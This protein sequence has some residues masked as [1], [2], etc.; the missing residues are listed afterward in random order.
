MALTNRFAN[1]YNNTDSYSPRNK[2][3][4]IKKGSLVVDGYDYGKNWS[5]ADQVK[6]DLYLKSL[7]FDNN[8]DM[9][10]YINQYNSP[11]A[12]VARLRDAGLN[13][14]LQSIDAGTAEGQTTSA[15]SAPQ[16]MSNIDRTQKVTTIA[17]QFLELIPQAIQLYQSI[18]GGFLDLDQKA[19]GVTSGI[20]QIAQ[21]E[22]GKQLDI[23]D[24]NNPKVVPKISIAHLPKRLQKRIENQYHTYIEDFR[25]RDLARSFIY[26]SKLSGETPRQDYLGLLSK[27]G[28]DVND[29]AFVKVLKAFNQVIAGSTKAHSQYDKDYYSK[30]NGTK[31]AETENKE[32]EKRGKVAD[33]DV[34]ADLM[35]KANE[36]IDSKEKSDKV[37]GYI[38]YLLLG[39]LK[40][41]S[42][43]AIQ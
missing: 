11:A 28:Y 43:G 30:K 22:L 38:M 39:L 7:E 1:A 29:D 19:I 27:Y 10:D 15:P 3:E 14:N 8:V 37:G 33:N 13:P 2:A 23:Q 5:D 32:V 35:S 21:T 12:Q 40:S 41:R 18:Q 9:I 31:L 26:K 42:A 16:G 4:G 17:Q 24:L 34:Y 36:L 20:D 25:H 6:Y